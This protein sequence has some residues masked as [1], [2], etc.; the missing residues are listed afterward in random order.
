MTAK[1]LFTRANKDRYG[2]GLV[3][4]LG[5]LIAYQGIRYH[6]GTLS[7]MGPGFFPTALGVILVVVGV[8]IAMVGSSA[9]PAQH[10]A[11]DGGFDWR[12]WSC[13]LTGIVGFIVLGQYGGLVPATFAVVFIS[14]LGDRN[15][16]LAGAFVLALAMVLICI[17][18][19][20]WA[21]QLQMPLFQ[22]G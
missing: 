22:W 15:N 3:L 9:T 5:L 4:L 18:M 21:L 7:S 10:E 20:W 2:G 12:G 14:A 16:T 1:T 11:L 17:G 13:I 19:F 8:L 6:V